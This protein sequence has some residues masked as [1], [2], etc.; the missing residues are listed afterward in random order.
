MAIFVS[1]KE[2]RTFGSNKAN[3]ATLIKSTPLTAGSN[4]LSICLFIIALLST[5]RPSHHSRPL[6]ATARRTIGS[7]LLP[8]ENV[9]QTPQRLA[10]RRQTAKH[11][12]QNASVI[13]RHG[14]KNRGVIP[15]NARPT[16]R[17]RIISKR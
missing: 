9:G 1:I 15:A 2:L 5:T 11:G 12:G 8:T 17:R 7:A 14:K 6:W 13:R 16:E 4:A 3:R 10:L